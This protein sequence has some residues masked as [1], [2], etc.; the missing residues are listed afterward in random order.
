MCLLFRCRSLQFWVALWGIKDLS[1]PS[2]YYKDVCL[3]V[4]K[5]IVCT[6]WFFDF[7]TVRLKPFYSFSGHFV[8]KIFGGKSHIKIE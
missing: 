7:S 1:L 2:S 3:D 6:N 4:E 8:F 5:F